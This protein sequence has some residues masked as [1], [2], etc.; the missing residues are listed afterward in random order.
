MQ[1]FLKCNHYARY[2]GIKDPYDIV[3]WGGS[4]RDSERI[5]NIIKILY[6]IFNK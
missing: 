3:S 4:V 5:R 2:S 1:I 6:K